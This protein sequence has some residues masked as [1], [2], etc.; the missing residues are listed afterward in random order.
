[1]VRETGRLGLSR[2][3]ER[4]LMRVGTV[5]LAEFR[6]EGKSAVLGAGVLASW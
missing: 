3:L 1:M 2:P 5:I 6:E 4:E